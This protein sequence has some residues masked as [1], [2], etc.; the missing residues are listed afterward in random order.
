MSG[1]SKGQANCHLYLMTSQALAMGTSDFKIRNRYLI[2]VAKLALDMATGAMDALLPE[3]LTADQ[4]C[5][6]RRHLNDTSR[7]AA[8]MIQ[9]VFSARVEA[10]N[11]RVETLNQAIRANLGQNNITAPARALAAL[12]N[13]AQNIQASRMSHFN[14]VEHVWCIM[15]RMRNMN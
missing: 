10:D 12:H 14:S 13:P 8:S 3:L 6:L 1:E 4:A 5:D 11:Q 9:E 15:T 2:S 7:G